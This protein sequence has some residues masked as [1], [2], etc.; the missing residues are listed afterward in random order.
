MRKAGCCAGLYV[1]SIHA[2]PRRSKF[3]K[4][5]ISYRHDPDIAD[6]IKR[7]AKLAGVPEAAVVDE[8]VRRHLRPWLTR[9][10]RERAA[11]KD[12]A[13]AGA[14]AALFKKS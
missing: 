3:S 14:L 2:M 7:A 13:L 6:L 12:K 9:H 1:P 5:N 8:C 10:L 4:V 11:L